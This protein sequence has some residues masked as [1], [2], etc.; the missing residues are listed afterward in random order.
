MNESEQPSVR[1][2]TVPGGPDLSYQDTGGD[3]PPIVFSH[4]L[5]MNRTM[6]Q[7]QVRE[8]AAQHR[9]I[10][11]DQRSH[12]DTAWRGDYTFWDS[13]RDLFSLLDHL[14]IERAVLA[15]M[16]QGGILSLRA[17]LLAPQRVAGLVLMD[18]QAGTLRPGSG[19][20]FTE[21]AA[22]WG[23]SGPD[24]AT[25]EWI[26]GI[27]L[28]PGVDVD[29]WYRSWG[30]LHAYQVQDAVRTLVGREDLTDRLPEIFAPALVVHGTA[31]ASTSVERARALAAGL[32]DCRGLQLVEN[33]PHAANLTHPTQVNAAIRSFLATL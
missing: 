23:D 21:I 16:S 10:V 3:G 9:C 15:G 26:G 31:D 17:S 20:T 7:P 19:D 18:T 27:I 12:G 29:H 2:V 6:F 4:G 8:F 30:R 11:W 13:A 25:L 28:G 1:R 14:G 5:F 33:A 24:Q 32:A 22:G